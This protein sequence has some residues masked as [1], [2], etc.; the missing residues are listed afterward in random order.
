MPPSP[1]TSPEIKH[2]AGLATAG[3][4]LTKHQ[5]RELGASVLAH[6]E[7]RKQTPH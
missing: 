5:Q 4:Q 7:P 1:I 6:I 2:L 3:V